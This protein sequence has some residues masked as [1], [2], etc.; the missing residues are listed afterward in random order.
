[1]GQKVNLIVSASNFVHCQPNVI[2]F[3]PYTLGYRKYQLDDNIIIGVVSYG[4]LEHVPPPDFQLFNFL[5][6]SEP[7]KL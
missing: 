3:G 5:V 6:T 2:I 7:S 1:M 4:A